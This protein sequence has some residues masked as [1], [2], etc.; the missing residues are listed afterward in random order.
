MAI[1]Y[2]AN[3]DGDVYTIFAN[4]HG[5]EICTIHG[6]TILVFRDWIET[7]KRV[8]ASA[9]PVAFSVKGVNHIVDR[10]SLYSAI[11]P[12][13]IPGTS[14]T[15]SFYGEDVIRDG[16]ALQLAIKVGRGVASYGEDKFGNVVRLEK[17]APE[18]GECCPETHLLR[19]LLTI[20]K[21]RCLGALATREVRYRNMA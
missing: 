12:H 5:Y 4:A 11:R 20:I 13:Q 9:G 17:N 14:M 3:V 19:N 10:E 8:L 16:M 2:T 6:F 7:A 18:S 15:N 21:F 1:G